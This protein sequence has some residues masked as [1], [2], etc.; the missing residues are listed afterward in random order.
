MRQKRRINYSAKIGNIYR[1][2][3]N[4][5]WNIIEKRAE[6][7]DRYEAPKR[8]L[9]RTFNKGEEFCQVSIYGRDYG[10][11]GIRMEKDWNGSIRICI[12]DE[13]GY[14]YGGLDT[15]NLCILLT[16]LRRQRQCKAE[17]KRTQQRLAEI[18]KWFHKKTA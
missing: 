16:A 18:N 5:M 6:T 15:D 1:A 12:E 8:F 10:V 14:Q 3:L 17:W 4:E 13:D 11:H 9:S 7:D 2:M